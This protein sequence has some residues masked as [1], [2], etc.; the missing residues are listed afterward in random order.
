MLRFVQSVIDTTHVQTSL[1]NIVSHLAEPYHLSMNRPIERQFF[2]AQRKLAS[3]AHQAG[4]R[5]RYSTF[6][7]SLLKGD[8]SKR[9]DFS[10]TGL[11]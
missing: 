8:A 10:Q 11:A 6:S 5:E 2:P 1:A 9:G 4:L 3:N 7:A